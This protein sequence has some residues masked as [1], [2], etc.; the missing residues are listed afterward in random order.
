MVVLVIKAM[1]MEIDKSDL[2]LG[3]TSKCLNLGTST[4]EPHYQLF[5]AKTGSLCCKNDKIF[6]GSIW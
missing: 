2:F 6:N 3:Q 1:I 5:H 4:L